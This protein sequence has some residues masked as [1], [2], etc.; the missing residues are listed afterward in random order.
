MPGHL[1]KLEE[2]LPQ[3]PL[4][5][6]LWD[7]LNDRIAQANGIPFLPAIIETRAAAA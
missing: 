1:H 5:L 4:G 3:T 6:S 2:N 7:H